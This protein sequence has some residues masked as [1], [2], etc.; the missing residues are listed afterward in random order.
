MTPLECLVLAMRLG[1]SGCIEVS[2]HGEHV[3]QIVLGGGRIA[4]ATFRGQSESLG[5]FLWRLGRITRQQ[6]NNVT[7]IYKRNNGEKKLGAILEESGFMSRPVLRRCLLLHI[8][9]A[10]DG[11]LTNGTTSAE[12]ARG[13]EMEDE[14]FMFTP[15]EVLPPN[16]LAEVEE[17]A[18]ELDL[19]DPSE[20]WHT[21]NRNNLALRPFTDFSG[22][23]ASAVYSFDGD[24][25]LAH[26]TGASDLAGLGVIAAAV[27]DAGVRAAG[28]SAL[29][30]LGTVTLSCEQGLLSATWLD[31]ERY[32]LHLDLIHSPTCQSVTA[33]SSRSNRCRPS[34]KKL[35]KSSACRRRSWRWTVR[36]AALWRP[37]W[38]RPTICQGFGAPPWTALPLSVETPLAPAR[39][40][41][42]T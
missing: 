10:L 34:M 31:K 8:R 40:P 33:R 1:W 35:G 28:S 16:V 38:W 29:G 30:D 21:L 7:A 4:W 2:S 25:V 36:W 39:R 37:T 27:L 18:E 3:G 20:M 17:Q 15:S 6:L 5:M 26:N 24:V 23:V 9:S 22:Y 13:P 42:P 41:R 19:C 14:P 11:L 12:M 32:Y